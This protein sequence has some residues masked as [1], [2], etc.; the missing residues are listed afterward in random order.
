MVPLWIQAVCATYAVVPPT[1]TCE[2]FQFQK[3]SFFFFLKLMIY[4]ALFSWLKI[5]PF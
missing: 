2:Q 5:L 4:F 1:V 3:Q